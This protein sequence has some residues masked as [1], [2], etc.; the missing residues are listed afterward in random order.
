MSDQK[1][2]FINSFTF[3]FTCGIM[4]MFCHLRNE[5]EARINKLLMD[6]ATKRGIEFHQRKEKEIPSLKGN[7][8][9]KIEIMN[10]QGG[11]LM[12]ELFGFPKDSGIEPSG[13]IILDSDDG[14]SK[15]FNMK[16]QLTDVWQ[17]E[18]FENKDGR[19]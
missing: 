3:T 9:E 19:C 12:G 7:Y 16:G 5:D 18:Q 15:R 4:I 13:L 11:Q 17:S 6:D 8:E 2:K 14:F 10:Y 1:F